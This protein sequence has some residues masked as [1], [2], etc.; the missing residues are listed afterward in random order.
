MQKLSRKPKKVK[1]IV[2]TPDK[3]AK[4]ASNREML[5]HMLERQQKQDDKLDVL[6]ENLVK[7]E[8]EFR[9]YVE[10]SKSNKVVEALAKK[11]RKEDHRYRN[12]LIIAGVG[13]TITIVLFVV[14][15]LLEAI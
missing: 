6:S 3:L 15:I 1:P 9:N 4:K 5:R 8:T 10:H 12:A 14:K 7:I 2:K 13:W 11:E